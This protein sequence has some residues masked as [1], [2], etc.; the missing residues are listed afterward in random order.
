MP[1]LEAMAPECPV[2]TSDTPA[3]VEIAGGA[4]LHVDAIS[5]AGFSIAIQRVAGRPD[6]L[7]A[8]LRERGRERAREFT[9]ERSALAT[10]RILRYVIER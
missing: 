8:R 5:A 4:A 2:I 7:A 1:V 6:D 9:W 3:L 10:Q